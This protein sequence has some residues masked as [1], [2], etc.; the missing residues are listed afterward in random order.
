MRV[1][2]AGRLHVPVAIDEG[3]RCLSSNDGVEHDGVV[4]RGRVLH[5]HGHV[6]ARRDKPVLLVF[7][8]ACTHRHVGKQVGQEA[9]VLGIEHLVSTEETRLLDDGQVHV[10]NGTDAGKQVGLTVGVGLMEH[11]HVAQTQRARLVG[12]EAWNED[13][14]AGHL[15]LGLGQAGAVLEYG[16]LAIGRAGADDDELARIRSVHNGGNCSVKGNFALFCL[17]RHRH[18]GLDVLR[19]GQAA[20]EFHSHSHAP[21]RCRL[22]HT[23]QVNA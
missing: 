21:R 23:Q 13:E 2:V 9:V 10:A 5:A 14:L 6:Q 17:R 1:G 8:R 12:V 11:A 20:L 15:F 4:A 22:A 3:V 19:V 16:V 7:N 18:L